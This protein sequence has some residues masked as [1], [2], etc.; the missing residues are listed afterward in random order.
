MSSEFTP[1]AT[2]WQGELARSV[3]LVVLFHGRG[4][5][6]LGIARLADLLPQLAT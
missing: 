3:P 1:P 4:D 5:T 6:D 2:V